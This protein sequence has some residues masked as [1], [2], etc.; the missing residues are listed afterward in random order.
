MQ[1]LPTVV[2]EEVTLRCQG[3]CWD[4]SKKLPE[5]VLIPTTCFGG[6]K[7]KEV[8]TVSGFKHDD[9]AGDAKRHEHEN[10]AKI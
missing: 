3:P 7:W 10:M 4:S 8:G 1:T 5:G 2:F 9:L 6:F